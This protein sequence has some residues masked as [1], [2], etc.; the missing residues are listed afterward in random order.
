MVLREKN[1]SYFLM[2]KNNFLF[3]FVEVAYTTSDF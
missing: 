1:I 3:A 2:K